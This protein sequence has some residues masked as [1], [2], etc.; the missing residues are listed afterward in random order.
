ML[1]IM[2]GEN[3]IS[4]TYL[5]KE[6]IEPINIL[7]KKGEKIVSIQLKNNE[8]YFIKEKHLD[9]INMES[10]SNKDAIVLEE[11]E[12]YLLTDLNSKQK[13]IIY[14]LPTYENSFIHLSTE[15]NNIITIGKNP[16]CTI[17]YNNKY[18]SDIHAKLY[19]NKGRWIIENHSKNLGIILNSNKIITRQKKIENGD[20]LFILGLKIVV[21]G[22]N[23][24]INNP[25][26]RIKCDPNFFSLIKDELVYDEKTIGLNKRE[27]LK[28]YYY[29]MPRIINS[30]QKVKFSIAAP[31]S[32]NE[33]NRMPLALTIGSTLSIGA[34]SLITCISTIVS[35]AKGTSS[36]GENIS[37][38]LISFTMLVS[39]MLIPTLTLK[40]ERKSAKRYEEKRQKKYREY[41][42]A[43]TEELIKLKKERK[44][45]LEKNYPTIQE[46]L[47]I[48]LNKEDRLW[49][50]K[51]NDYD[52]LSINLGVGNDTFVNK[53]DDEANFKIEQDDLQDIMEE[54]VNKA[55][56][57]ENVPITIS[58]REEKIVGFIESNNQN[59]ERF[60]QE[61]LVQL[62]AF[63]S[64][65]DLKLVFML[66]KDRIQEW[67]Y[68]KML[69][70]VW[71]KY[72]TFRFLGTDY[73]DN[74]EDISNYLEKE[75]NER[76]LNSSSKEH[77]PYYLII[78][79]DYRKIEDLNIISKII[80]E[81]RNLGFGIFCMENTI[82]ELP[83]EC[84]TFIKM[85]DE[86]GVIL[87]SEAPKEEQ[88]E[89]IADNHN[90][91]PFDEIIQKISN[92][93]IKLEIEEE[94]A[95]PEEYSF[96]DMFNASNIR[97][98]DIKNRWKNNDTITSIA[99]PIGINEFGK[100]IKLD[101]HE[102]A[103]GP[104]GLIAGSTGS[105]K[106]RVYNNIYI[107][108]S[109]KLSPK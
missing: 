92:I 9:I 108:F 82:N 50:R 16:K 43:K 59:L 53:T 54:L 46:C 41:I 77:K 95:F 36:L 106:I 47:D 14:C 85:E 109:I 87:K 80:N 58:L 67:K 33:S 24:F 20:I 30:N 1:I 15:Y 23:I 45:E 102:K 29:R 12:N 63:H 51:I 66:K 105:R 40:W 74:M 86:K 91:I 61:M 5:P 60:M 4:K 56:T 69:P 96:L 17:F 39:M 103:H 38:L 28:E 107:I 57:I 99:T 68:I 37:Q 88:K 94:N 3:F 42:N 75:F 6:H 71:D 97:E 19:F 100:L 78:T 35:I 31:P 62:M 26:N 49:E 18:I 34:I 7:G 98:L 93:P 52:F 48:I 83:Q 2:Q 89:F 90:P 10:N 84:K 72:N 70:Y 101:I 13:Y 64:Y 65:D 55:Q 25:K 27:N 81:K 104:H 32:K 21:I 22:N 8:W 79:D 11:Y 76:S 44:D 73:A